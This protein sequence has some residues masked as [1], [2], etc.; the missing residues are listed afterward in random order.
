MGKDEDINLLDDFLRRLV[1]KYN[2]LEKEHLGKH[3]LVHLTIADMRAMHWIGK[4]RRE[5]MTSLAKHLKLT[6]GTLT[7]TVDR[8]VKRGYVQRDR[9]EDDRRVVEVSLSP[10]GQEAF[11]RIQT[12]KK[13]IAE[14]IFNDLSDEERRVL[15]SILSKLTR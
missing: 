14:R 4:S 6:V 1:H 9:L 15:K 5:R 2:E 12:V 8:L 3:D 7:T 13:S 11:D 10:K